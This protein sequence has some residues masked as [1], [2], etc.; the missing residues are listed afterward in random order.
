LN[1]NALLKGVTAE[2]SRRRGGENQVDSVAF[3][4]HPAD[5][6]WWLGVRMQEDGAIAAAPEG[7]LEPGAPPDLDGGTIVSYRSKSSSR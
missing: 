3:R 5:A 7:Q 4:Q 6:E 2:Y 1:D